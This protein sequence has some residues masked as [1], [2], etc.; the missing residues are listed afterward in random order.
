MVVPLREDA[1]L[2]FLPYSL[3]IDTARCQLAPDVPAFLPRLAMSSLVAKTG[4]FGGSGAQQ[5]VYDDAKL[6]LAVAPAASKGLA[7]LVV[8]RRATHRGA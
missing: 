3:S 5:L 8:T 1:G 7:D 2:R 6:P 4:C